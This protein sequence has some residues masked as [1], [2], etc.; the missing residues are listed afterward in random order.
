LKIKIGSFQ[1]LRKFPK[2]FASQVTPPVSMTPA[3]NFPTGI[4]VVV[5]T[6]GKFAEM[7]NPEI[8]SA[9]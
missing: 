2:I 3:A 5:D 7:N 1:I 9:N 4:A 6:G 8:S